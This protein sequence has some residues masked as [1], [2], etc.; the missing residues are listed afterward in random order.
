MRNG[1]ARMLL[2]M[3]VLVSGC[4]SYPVYDP[5]YDQGPVVTVAPPPPLYEYYG[6]PPVAG[7]VWIGGYW[8]WGGASYVWV[9]GRWEPP[10]PGYHWIP[11]GWGQH[12]E[13]WRPHGGRWEPDYHRPATPRPLPHFEQQNDRDPR[14][15]PPREPPPK[16]PDAPGASD[17]GGR[18][19]P[20]LSGRP[21]GDQ[22]PDARPE[23]VP[24]P[25]PEKMPATSP[26]RGKSRED[27]DDGARGKRRDKDER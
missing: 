1:I 23:A 6:F 17:N 19:P 20:G 12:G 24:R 11:H 5:Y 21:Q 25:R 26:E 8:S 14:P 4:T 18:Q 3:T 27:A 22:R 13:H 10:R 2:G 7:Y 15:Q 9:P 16:R